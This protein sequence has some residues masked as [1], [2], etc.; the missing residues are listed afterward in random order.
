MKN[1]LVCHL[2]RLDGNTP[3]R[4]ALNEFGKE[5]KAPRGRPKT[6]SLGVVMNDIKKYSTLTVI[7]QN[8]DLTQT[9]VS[10]EYLASLRKEWS[11]LFNGM[12]L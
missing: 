2:L 1:Y 3:A 5:T 12:M 4:I 10:L 8:S 6:T 7:L 9:I 11:T